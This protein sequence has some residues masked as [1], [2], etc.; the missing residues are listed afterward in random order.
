MQSIPAQDQEDA[1]DTAWKA[2]G[3]N[4]IMEGQG[5]KAIDDLYRNGE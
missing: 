3:I 1:F 4:A 5:G 2:P